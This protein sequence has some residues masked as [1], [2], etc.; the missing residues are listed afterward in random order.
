[1]SPEAFDPDAIVKTCC[2][3]ESGLFLGIN[4]LMACSRGALMSP[5]FYTTEE[6]AGTRVTKAMIVERRKQLITLLNDDHTDMDCKRCLLVEEKHYGD[7][8][9]SM[10]DHLDLQNYSLC[11]LRC[12]YCTYTR[13]DVH[14]P[15]QYDAL[16]ILN[17]FSPEDIAWNAHVDFAGGEPTLLPHLDELLA[18]FKSRGIRVLMH[19][20]G[21]LF[22]QDIFAG[23][24]DGSIY[25]ATV[26][27]DAGTP[28]TYAQ[29]RGRDQYV[30]VLENLCRYATAGSQGKG[31]LSVK[32]IFCATNHSDD[33]IAGFAYA[34]LAIR[35]QQVWL[36]FDFTPLYFQ[37]DDFDFAPLVTGY[38]KL[39]VILKRHG[40]VAFH[41]FEEAVASVSQKAREIMDQVYA[42][43]A[44]LEAS[45]PESPEDL[46]L[47]DFRTP[48]AGAL[49]S[50][51]RFTA[52]PWVIESPSG[53]REAFPLQG[54]RV[55]LVPACPAT[56][57]LMSHPSL[58]GAASLAF[59]DRSPIQQRKTIQGLQVHPYAAIPA[60]NPEIILIAPPEKH[61]SDI[62]ASVMRY[63]TPEMRVAELVSSLDPRTSAANAETPER[64]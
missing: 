40:I 55:L 37:Q 47:G 18:Y 30:Q 16:A 29:L 1:M 61:R 35:P 9:F 36:T 52:D 49:Q 28:S 54:K 15:P 44:A 42:E 39:Y 10:L 50:I 11:N 59:V 13:K 38:A 45:S 17:L 4:G 14:V 12:T 5:V 41:Y 7:I 58:Q 46:L 23:L 57:R 62:L 34:M 56:L 53:Q 33:D 6:L 2:K 63:A 3:L 48:P 8:S 32:Y 51:S 20:N 21:V 27:V 60:L 64:G 22:S 19:T 26:S 24:A 31:M 43:I 25:M